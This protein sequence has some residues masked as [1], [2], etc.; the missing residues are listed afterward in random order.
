M[1]GRAIYGTMQTVEDRGKSSHCCG[2]PGNLPTPRSATRPANWT[3]SSGSVKRGSFPLA[4]RM[5]S[6]CLRSRG[7]SPQHAA[8]PGYC[9]SLDPPAARCRIYALF[10]G[11]RKG[12][13]GRKVRLPANPEEARYLIDRQCQH[14]QH[15][16]ELMDWG[17]LPARVRRELRGVLKE[18]GASINRAS[19]AL[20][21][22]KH[23][24][25]R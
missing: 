22:P 7:F 1:D 9:Q 21:K 25:N 11:S 5:S 24:G 10:G 14:L 3:S 8:T 17:S 6:A 12:K 2:V 20:V 23:A 15:Q 19:R 18:L 16:L 4:F 13:V